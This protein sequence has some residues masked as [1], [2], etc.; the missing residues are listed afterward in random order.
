MG[1][2]D[3]SDNLNDVQVAAVN[4]N[5][6]IGAWN[7]TANF[8]TARDALASVAYNGSIYVIGGY[9][10]S[11]LND[12]QFA[13]MDAS[14]T[15]GAWAATTGLTTARYLHA[16]VACGGYL[17]VI[18]GSTGSSFL[19]DVQVAPMN[20]DGTVGPW[21]ATTSLSIPRFGHTSVAANGFLYVL[22]G[23][24]S[25]GLLNDVLYAPINSNGTLG[26]WSATTSFN[27]SRDTHASVAY[28]GYL[29]VI[30]GYSG[31]GLLNDV[32]FAPMNSD[33]TVGAWSGTASFA[34]ARYLHTSVAYG[35][36]LYVMG[37]C[38]TVSDFLN[39]VQF[40]PISATG[41]VG[42][43]SATTSLDRARFGHTS[44]ATNGFLYVIGGNSA[45]GLLND[46]QSA[47][48]ISNGAIGAWGSTTSFGTPSDTHASVAYNGYLYLIAGY[49]GSGAVSD[50]QVVTLNGP[51]AR[52]RYSKLL[53]VG[54][55]QIVQSIT[56][57]NSGHKGVTNLGYAVAPSSTALF[58][59]PATVPDAAS[60][61]LYTA[62]LGTCGRWL[63]A[64][65]DL[66]DTQSATTDGG[67]GGGRGDVLDFTVNYSPLLGIGDT[68]NGAKTTA[69]HLTWSA[70]PAATSYSV[71][72]CNANGGPC[73]PA[74]LA[75]TSNLYYDDA[76][77]GDGSTYWYAVVAVNGECIA[78]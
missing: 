55:D 66:D 16:S 4:S 48:I 40:A 50:V 73:T 30:G 13:P 41:T 23:N 33:G 8:S 12:V 68:L 74:T 20:A 37:G 5:G 17:Y 64:S 65:F 2:W 18:G 43:W 3:G 15:V 34:T 39:D 32:Q 14:G 31:S 56:F 27:T 21:T 69:V 19:G 35:G 58:G 22:G 10:G 36:Y 26:A 29:Y 45:G 53:D 59:A 49:G 46:V 62:G 42:A 44:V 11:Y 6:T 7:T 75:S 63:W 38:Y 77:L 78:P 47:P 61:T 67:G 72:R 71:Q 24:S 25:G 51:A 52:A 54:S 70:S 28:G 76:V 60:G 57:S 9:G 1:G